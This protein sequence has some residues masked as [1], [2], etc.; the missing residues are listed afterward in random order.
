MWVIMK[1][2]TEFPLEFWK[3][4]EMGMVPVVI[5][6]IAYTPISWCRSSPKTD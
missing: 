3:E 5:T 6:L 1:R 2:S 4:K